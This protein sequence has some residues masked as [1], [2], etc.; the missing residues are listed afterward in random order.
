M[1][2]AHCYSSVNLV[3][4]TWLYR[5]P[6]QLF[7]KAH[8]RRVCPLI[9]QYYLERIFFFMPLYLLQET[10]MGAHLFPWKLWFEFRAI[11]FQA[12]DLHKSRYNIDNLVCD[13]CVNL[14]ERKGGGGEMHMREIVKGGDDHVNGVTLLDHHENKFSRGERITMS[15]KVQ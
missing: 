5:E 8:D 10:F 1:Q 4:F 9:S 12:T 2:S 3:S 13:L 11:K 14:K 7:T 15:T 6:F